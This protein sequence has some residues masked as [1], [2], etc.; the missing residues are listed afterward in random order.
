MNVQRGE[1]S[2]SQMCKHLDVVGIPAAFLDDQRLIAGCNLL[3]AETLGMMHDQLIGNHIQACL[4][5]VAE[6]ISPKASEDP[7]YQFSNANVSEAIEDACEDNRQWYRL[8]TNSLPSGEICLLIDVTQEFLYID[9]IAFENKMRDQLLQDAKIGTW[10]LDPETDCF[11][12]SSNIDIGYKQR[13]NPIHLSKAD[14]IKHPEDRVNQLEIYEKI[15]KSGGTACSEMRMLDRNGDWQSFQVHYRAGRKTQSGDYDLHGLTQIVTPLAKA[16]DEANA[17]ARRL[18][19]AFEV[20]RAGIFEYD[21][22]T[23]EFWISDEYQALIG[24]DT[25]A[26]RKNPKDRFEAFHPDD[27]AKVR[28]TETKALKS[29]Y[30]EP[31]DV[32]M[33]TDKGYRWFRLYFDAI[34][35]ENNEPLHTIGLILDIE[36]IKRQ[37]FELIEAREAAEAATQSKSHFF[38]AIS[39]EIR[40]PLNGVLGMAQALR[41]SRLTHEQNEMVSTILESGH[42]LMAILNDVLDLSK[43]EAGKLRIAPSPGDLVHTVNRI[44]QLFEPRARE[45][46]LQFK[47]EHLDDLPG[48]I[49]FDRVRIGQCLSNL[50]SNAIKFTD[51]GEVTVRVTSRHIEN[52][53]HEVSVSVADTGIGMTNETLKDLFQPFTQADATISQKYGG[54]GLGLSIAQRLAQL[55]G[56]NITAKSEPGRGSH[57]EFT[58]IAEASP[59]INDD[60]PITIPGHQEPTR[61]GQSTNLG[62]NGKRILVVDD[63]PT[64]RKVIKLFFAPYGINLV[65]AIDGKQALEKLASEAIDLVLLDI[66]MPVM[67]GPETIKHIRTSSEHW[68]D[69]PVIALTA[70]AMG[71]E[72]ER[73]L[74]MG[75]NS[76]ISKPVDQRDL[77]SQI[78][79]TLYGD[80]LT[81]E[82]FESVQEFK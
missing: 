32:R 59:Q 37:E 27:W 65:E 39:H 23:K 57:F 60:N 51:D 53:Q 22:K 66:H 79:T 31:I 72:H 7:V 36:D 73:Y 34:S 70:N 3:F 54:T 43:V 61:L 77:I 6:N 33:V 24:K 12:F 74:D 63:N 11:T 21:Y 9:N 64:N 13:L 4:E 62:L 2:A 8:Q 80:K 26:L 28:E 20:A 55:M 15:K 46:G 58:F 29:E 69:I 30:V 45:K 5:Q 35:D 76:Y 18:Q 48:K 40:T 52:N 47:L 67:D 16:R 41:Q 81:L 49:S 68:K 82:D 19:L 10:R 56:G 42:S 17:L 25:V 71:G 14:Q 78:A 50:I 38:A 75:M 1:L 44:K